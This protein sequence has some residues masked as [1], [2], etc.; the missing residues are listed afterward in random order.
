MS[1]SRFAAVSVAV[2]F[3]GAVTLFQLRD[4]DS[5][6]TVEVAG[7]SADENAAQDEPVSAPTTTAPLETAPENLGPVPELVQ[8]DGWL[9]TDGDSFDT[10]KGEVTIVQFWTYGCYNCTNTL[11]HLQEIYAN[12]KDDGLEIIGVHSPEFEREEDP[13]GIQE[14]ADR[15]GVSWP[16]A[17][18]TQKKNF[19]SWQGARRFWPR[20]FIIDQNGDIRFDK[21]GEG[22]YQEIEATVAYLLENGA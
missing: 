1:R 17:L 22:K 10:V 3:G 14:A 9:Q 21:I 11:P 7:T 8:L 20:T 5:T 18:D 12:H 6:A 2:F 15:L 4:T 19:R 16:I 13:V